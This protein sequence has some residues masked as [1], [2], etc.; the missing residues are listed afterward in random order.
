MPNYPIK[1]IN[2]KLNNPF[3][4]DL[5]ILYN[6]SRKIYSLEYMNDFIRK[7]INNTINNTELILRDIQGYPKV[8]ESGYYLEN[9]VTETILN[10]NIYKFGYYV[11]IRRNVFSLIGKSLNSEKLW[12][13]IEKL[14]QITLIYFIYTQRYNCVIDDIDEIEKEKLILNKDL[15]LIYQISLTEKSFNFSILKKIRL[16]LKNGIWIYFK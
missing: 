3:D 14:K 4:I 15:Y 8:S 13:K 12:R 9:K 5:Y 7:V 1:Y 2:V 10:E 16:I 11:F 6:S